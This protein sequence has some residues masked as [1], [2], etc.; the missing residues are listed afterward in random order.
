MILEYDEYCRGRTLRKVIGVLILVCFARQVD[1]LFVTLS[2]HETNGDEDSGET[3]MTTSAS[4]AADG[5]RQRP[6]L[7]A[8]SGIVTGSD[9]LSQP[10][11]LQ[12][13]PP[14]YSRVHCVGDTFL[15]NAW[16]YRSCQY[17]NLCWS[18]QFNDW[19]L[20]T[21]PPQQALEQK[22]NQRFSLND[23]DIGHRGHAYPRSSSSV[24]ESRLL[25]STIGM[26]QSR[27]EQ[28]NY[29]WNPKILHFAGHD[30]TAMSMDG[31]PSTATTEPYV[32]S[33]SYEHRFM[34]GDMVIIPISVADI[35][36]TMSLVMETLFSVYNL[37][38]MFGLQNKKVMLH[39]LNNNTN[40]PKRW[41]DCNRD[42]SDLL[43][44]GVNWMGYDIWTHPGPPSTPTIRSGENST[45]DDA[46]KSILFCAPNAASGLGMLT[47][48]GLSSRGLMAQDLQLSNNVG[49]GGLFWKFRNHILNMTMTRIQ[50]NA[51]EATMGFASGD[52]AFRVHVASASNSSSFWTDLVEILVTNRNGDDD[53]PMIV[54][55]G[56]A[57]N[58]K[59]AH[60]R[61]HLI[62]LASRTDFWIA[63]SYNDEH[64]WPALFLPRGA[65]LLLLYDE[66]R[67]TKGRPK[68]RAGPIRL[69]FDVWNHI[70]HLKVHWLSLQH[71]AKGLAQSVLKLIRDEVFGRTSRRSIAY[72]TQKFNHGT[73]NNNS[74]RLVRN[75]TLQSTVHCVG[76]NWQWDALNYRSCAFQSICFDTV[77]EKFAISPLADKL[78][79]FLRQ[80]DSIATD[81]HNKFVSMGETI[82]IGNGQPWF[83]TVLNASTLSTTMSYFKLE[84]DIVWLPLVPEHDKANNP[85]HLL[86]DYWMPLYNLLQMFGLEKSRL[87]LVNMDPPCLSR[88]DA[89]SCLGLAT[90]YLSLLGVQSLSFRTTS[91]SE[92]ITN[93]HGDGSR[94]VCADNA[95]AGIGM[96]TDHG[97]KKHGQLFEDY[98]IA[99]NVGRGVFFWDFR[100]FML[101]H[102]GELS[103]GRSPVPGKITFLIN[104]SNNPARRRDFA[105]QV[106]M[107]RRRFPKIIVQ[108]VELDK[109]SLPEQLAVMRETSICVSVI[110][111]SVSTAMFM[112]RNTSLIL[113]YNNVNDFVKGG[114]S[115]HMPN[116]MDWD[117]WN[118]ASYLRLHWLPLK[119]LDSD[120]DL[121]LLGDLLS[122]ELASTAS[123]MEKVY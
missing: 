26:T 79:G 83:P 102:M 56:N 98:K 86:W 11:L 20:V 68:K 54:T 62:R 115:R 17:Q 14:P 60:E 123:F 90:K 61:D 50:N 49:R 18:S 57:T 34:S 114:P 100:N 109:L 85:G 116:F 88:E 94:F 53:F 69:D 36:S 38:N 12:T 9:G 74:V 66:T 92:L 71:D 97:F 8:G 45:Q 13:P 51:T 37:V 19:V 72:P 59:G 22:W 46:M 75:S 39:V 77:E 7:P 121:E 33:K 96:L 99:R 35:T 4:V 104:S 28:P 15:P 106:S 29:R 47:A 119:T 89:D 65:T 110:G 48:N 101:Q 64:T 58:N 107:A 3:A 91:S 73:F 81:Y 82:R 30:S 52:D 23:V 41:D 16:V 84:E 112:E 76:E 42:C 80:H 103:R 2:W 111:G 78:S 1:F 63:V 10:T 113:F 24:N 70:S 32:D 122:S 43:E 40:D 120:K 95:I 87:L 31:G 105:E 5:T 44:Q 93:K 67:V 108:A 6:N 25:L 21:S 55:L 27:R 118:N 117:F